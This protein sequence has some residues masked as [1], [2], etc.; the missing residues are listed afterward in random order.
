LISLNKVECEHNKVHVWR[1]VELYYAA[2]N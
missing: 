1:E 2:Q